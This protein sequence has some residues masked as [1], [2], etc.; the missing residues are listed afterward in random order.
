M[1]LSNRVQRIKPS[2]TLAIT[3]RAAQLRAEGKDII[4]FGA[5]EPDFDTPNHIRQA[6]IQAINDGFTRYTAVNGTI[7][8]RNAITAKFSRDNGL[9]YTADQ[10]LVSVGGKQSFYNL[11]QA[12]LNS[13]DEV[14]I[15]A[16][17]WVSYP[18]MVLLADA[19]PV[20]VSS[21]IEHG[22]KMTPDQLEAA[23]THRT[24]LV[25]INS[26]SNPTGAAY[27]K[28]E[29]AALGEVLLKYP[30]IIV[31]SDDIYETI[32]LT[33][34]PFDNILTACPALYDQSIILN[35]VSKAY[36]MTGWRIGYAA[37]PEKLISAMKKIQSQSTSNPTSISQVAA[38]AALEG[39]QSCIPLMNK[40]FMDRHEFVVSAL[41]RIKGVECLYSKGAFYAFPAMHEAINAIPDVNNDVE[42][43][44]YL[45]N[46]AG[47]ALVPGSAFGLPGYMRLSFATS[48]EN[49]QEGLKRITLVLSN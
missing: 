25:V 14:I 1:E 47:V 2:P 35:G 21:G 29:L 19:T 13:G 15:P 40:A 30:D 3:A 34:E 46:E 28:T 38:Q 44:E 36:A 8:L 11:A 37:G 27:S 10:V 4:G 20:I 23:I 48:M 42:F 5:G 49:L 22:F 17:Y 18:D 39:D 26:P 7:E 33:D 31:A 9:Q 24:R 43:G 32:L 16:P 6:A 45:I 12:L 41:N